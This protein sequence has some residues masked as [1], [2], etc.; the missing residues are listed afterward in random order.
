MKNL[1]KTKKKCI[2]YFASGNYWKGGVTGIHHLLDRLKSEYRVIFVNSLGLASITRVRKTTIFARIRARLLSYIKYLKIDNGYTIFSPIHFPIGLN[3]IEHLNSYLINIQFYF[4][5]KVLKIDKP[6][7]IISS[8]KAL[9]VI[10]KIPCSTL[11]YMYSD[12]FSAYRE[13]ANRDY[14]TKLDEELKEK[15]DFVVSNL[16]RTY[17]QLRNSSFSNKSIYLPH[18]VDF[19]LFNDALS[20]STEYPNDMPCGGSPLIGYYGTLTNSNDWELICYLAKARPNYNFIFIGKARADVDKEVYN[21]PNVYFLGYKPYNTLP[22]YLKHFTVCLMFWKPTEWIYNSNPLKT[23]EFLSMG[24][25]IVSIRIFELET[26][27]PDLIFHCSTRNDFL[28]GIDRAILEDSDELKQRR[29][30]AV[31]SD[32]WEKDAKKIIE[33][34]E[35]KNA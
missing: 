23:K 2:V 13:I 18:S 15:A 7:V 24:K 30:D 35:T 4:I 31:R 1:K 22:T 12:M 3:S 27:F 10:N 21:L 9:S 5:I 28:T 29:I 17:D 16:R 20:D 33:L 14:I 32:S 25:P 6:H 34:L 8:P 11:I 26:N 19:H